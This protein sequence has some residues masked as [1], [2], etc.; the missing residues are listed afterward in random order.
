MKPHNHWVMSLTLI[1][2]PF[3]GGC[4]ADEEPTLTSGGSVQMGGSV[5]DIA[6]GEEMGAGE[7]MTS[8]V[9]SLPTEPIEGCVGPEGATDQGEPQPATSEECVTCE[10]ATRATVA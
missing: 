6:A 1:A 8:G 4:K 10:G 7:Q 5:V 9:D 2:L 3:L